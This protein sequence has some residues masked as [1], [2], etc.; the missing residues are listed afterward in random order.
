MGIVWCA[1]FQPP[2]FIRFLYNAFLSI[3]YFLA[4][5]FFIPTSSI[6][7]WTAEKGFKP[8]TRKDFPRWIDDVGIKNPIAR[9]YPIER[10]ALYKKRMK[11]GGWKN[12]HQTMPIMGA[13]SNKQLGMKTI[14]IEMK[15]GSRKY[16]TINGMNW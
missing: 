16:F 12:A 11:K 13:I 6:H 9:K 5:G 1:F 7:R 10:K 14:P 3:G 2:F 4:I 15:K 8:L